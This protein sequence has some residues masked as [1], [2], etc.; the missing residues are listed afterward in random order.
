LKMKR[1]LLKL[2]YL[3]LFT[4]LAGT[5]LSINAQIRAYRV[6][7]RQVQ[8]LLSR[9]ET[10]TDR[11]KA[12]SDRALD[13]S[14]L[15]GTRTEDSLN[16]M[17][18]AFERATNALRDNFNS[19]R[20]TG[21]N[22][23]EVIGRAAVIDA[24]VMRSR[25]SGQ[26]PTTWSRIKA[27][28]NTLAGYYSVRANWDAPV[29]NGGINTGIGGYSRANDA[30]VRALLQRLDRRSTTFKNVVGRN[31]NRSNVDGTNREDNINAMMAAFDD[32]T[33][34]LRNSFNSGRSTG[35]EMQEVLN[36]AVSINRFMLNNQLND[37]AENEWNQIRTDLNALAGFYS[38]RAD[39]DGS[40]I[41][42]GQ[43]G[44][45]Y[46]TTEAE[47]RTVL[48]RL[49]NRSSAF[50]Q[51]F[52]RWAS[53]NRV[54]PGGV[55]Q[56]LN[57]FDRALEAYS[58]NY[59]ISGSGSANLQRLLSE[60]ASINTFL[61]SNNVN[62]DVLNSWESVRQDLDVLAGYYRV[63][64]TW[65][66][67]SLNNQTGFGGSFDTRLTGQYRLN[68]SLSDNVTTVVDRAIVNANFEANRR[69]R[70]RRNL[71]TRLNPSETVTIEKRGNDITIWAGA[72]TP[73]TLT[74][75]GAAIS[76]TS[77]N[78]RT[79]NTTIAAT[80]RDVTI[81][82]EGDR[83]ND[84]FVSFTPFGNDQLRVVRRV[85]LENQNEMVTVTSVYD[86]TSSNVD[87]NAIGYNTGGSNTTNRATG[88]I[89]PNSTTLTATL[90]NAI[91]TRN[92]REGDRFTLTVTSPGQFSGA[93]IEGVVVGQQS[94]AVTGRANLSMSFNTIRMRDGRS[95]NFAGIIDRIQNE[96]GDVVN[97]N[98]EGTVRDSSQT[99]KTVT[100]AG[101]GAALG[102][103][104]GA[105][106]GGGQGAAVGAAVG[107]G[108]G[109]GT[110]I[111][112]G[113]DNLEL[114]TGSQFTI[115]ATGPNTVG[116]R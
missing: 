33:R 58:R 53:R 57:Q 50:R 83:M 46:N 84:Y 115:T 80:D 35:A 79:V 112:Q 87:W 40:P 108:A 91:S 37:R 65:G 70:V 103:L 52:N 106:A 11:F 38:V 67:V 18:S 21:A 93:V 62:R 55:R 51:A 32:A 90:D 48:S 10:N 34:R 63:T 29:Y 64:H 94:G 3:I 30:Q 102:A 1:N 109:A 76:E 54:W 27:D 85:Y 78:G 23:E 20:S 111:L 89:V 74:A 104:I 43:T 7:D 107:A 100:R 81:S 44:G 9:I 4:L 28:L 99:T 6:T 95:Y 66:G 56:D 75:G 92:V 8:D 98:N 31:L 114:G 69:D 45:Y 19:R 86:R 105:I 68:R 25:L 16:N 82:Y 60:A 15:D 14:V 110:V 97:V 5:T 71:E 77:P 39:W 36:R 59:D 26:A 116:I 73:V 49:D 101:I 42:T 24:F 96:R 61:T 113:R 88:F 13:R 72:G 17:I 41:V 47:V 2:N 22:V 12:Q